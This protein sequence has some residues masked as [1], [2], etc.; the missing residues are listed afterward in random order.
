MIFFYLDLEKVSNVKRVLRIFQAISNLKINFAKSCLMRVELDH[1]LMEEWA[2]VV[3]CR[4]D[5]LPCSYLGLPLELNATLD[6][7][8]N[9]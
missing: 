7:F 9:R 6:K 3:G 4:C 5:G 8:K 1:A 2:I